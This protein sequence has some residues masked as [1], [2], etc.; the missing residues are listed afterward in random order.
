L[1]RCRTLVVGLVA[2]G[3]M[4]FLVVPAAQARRIALG[5]RTLSQGMRGTDVRV[6]QDFLTRVGV[7]TSVDGRYGPGTKS[8][9]R[10]WERRSTL[11]VD[12]RVSKADAAVLRGQVTNGQS[13][14]QSVPAAPVA[15]ATGKATLGPDGLAVAP[16]DAPPAVQQVIAAGNQ[17]IG[18]PYRYGGGH[19]NFSLDTGYDCSGSVSF[20]LNGG[21]LIDSPL[22]SGPLASWGE[23]G[24]GAW[25]TVYANAGHAFM[26]VAGLRLDTGYNN[27]TSSGPKWSTK[28]RPTGGFTARHPSGL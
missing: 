5:D 22:P 10:T 25:I 20:A 27:A 9:V 12:G 6:L 13:V 28:M 16:A 11:R 17:L 21:A 3:L 18:K 23:P 19:K 4:S 15:P 1:S 26:V 2:F 24:E 8:R 7:K 14:L